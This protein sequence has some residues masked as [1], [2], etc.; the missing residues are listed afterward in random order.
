M[1]GAVREDS[2]HSRVKTFS[3]SQ[4]W[5]STVFILVSQVRFFTQQELDNLSISSGRCFK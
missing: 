2:G 3:C 4:E 1:V 5:R